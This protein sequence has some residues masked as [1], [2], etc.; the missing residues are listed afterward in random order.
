MFDTL[1]ETEWER[2]DRAW[3]M[4]EAGDLEPARVAVDELIRSRGRH[5]DISVLEA[6]LSIEEGQAEQALAALRSAEDSADP[7][8]FFH[9]RALAH[10]HLVQ[11]EAA[12]AD[13]EK[14]LAIR[15]HMAEVHGVLAKIHDFLGDEARSAEHA[16]T[17]RELD[18][19][20]FPLPMEMNDETFDGLVEASLLEL[21][22][23]VREHLEE[24]PVL[25]EPMPSRDVLVSERPPLP[26]DILG[27]FVGRHLMGRQHDDLPGSPGAIYLFRKNLLRM[28]T[29]RDDLAREVRVTVQHEVGHLLGLDED[30]LEQWGLE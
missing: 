20:D 10:F 27:L 19:E 28:C 22:P 3:D 6:A 7:A 4:V 30:D 17:A 12:C 1:T 16:A 29:D 26:P 23:R 9:V 14:A 18:P 25:V 21:P 8:L 13:A 11:V 15:P 5:A 2:V 24:I